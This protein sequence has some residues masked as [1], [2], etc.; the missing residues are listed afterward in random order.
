M[1]EHLWLL[2]VAA[3]AAAAAVVVHRSVVALRESAGLG[4]AGARRGV[5]VATTALA[6]LLALPA[7]VAAVLLAGTS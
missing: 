5:V 2:V 4:P 1:S 6:G 7:A 3:L